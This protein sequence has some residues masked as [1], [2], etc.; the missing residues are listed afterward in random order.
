MWIPTEVLIDHCNIDTG[1]DA[2]ALKSVR[3]MEAVRLGRPTENVV[4]KNCTLSSSIFPGLGIGSDML[5]YP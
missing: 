1:D 4:I 2:I 3:G 5:W